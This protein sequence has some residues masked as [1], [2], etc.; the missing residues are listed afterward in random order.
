MVVLCVFLSAACYFDYRY[1]RI[2]NWLILGV[3]CAGLLRT[4]SE[5]G[6]PGMGR[7]LVVGVMVAA[8]L[9][10][11]FKIGCMGAGDVKLFGVCAG[12]LPGGKALYFLFFS[13][14]FSAISSIFH[15]IRRSD[16]KERFEYLI[17]YLRQVAGSGS[18][19]L[20]FHSEGEYRAAGVCLA[21]PML[22]SILLYAGGVY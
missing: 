3:G 16:A 1:A 6:I 10:P 19:Q 22:I 20:Y 9:Y 4:L 11:V 12:Y 8:L 15:F 13:L 14:L 7:Y 2:P 18:W 21:G 5:E 17:D